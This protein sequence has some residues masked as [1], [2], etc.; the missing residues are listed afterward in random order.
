MPNRKSTK[1][2][3]ATS[4]RKPL[5]TF[6]KSQ[7]QSVV[8]AR[9][10]STR[11]ASRD[12][13]VHDPSTTTPA[14][15]GQAVGD[16]GIHLS[17]TTEAYM[18][19]IANPSDAPAAGMAVGGIPSEKMKVWSRGS[20]ATGT[21]GFG[22]I[23][24]RPATGAA[25][26]AG[27][28]AVMGVTSLSSYTGSTMSNVVG[29][30]TQAVIS[31]STYVPSQFSATGVKY[32]LVAAEVRVRYVGTEL[33]RGGNAVV[34]CDPNHN[35]VAAYGQAQLL[36]NPSAGR[37]DIE[38]AEWISCK[39]NG[40]VDPTEENYSFGFTEADNKANNWCMAIA[41]QSAAVAQPF[42]YE[43]YAH[44]EIIGANSTNLSSTISD[45]VG[46]GAVNTAA[47]TAQIEHP[48]SHEEPDYMHKLASGALHV[49]ANGASRVGDI[50]GQE[51]TAK[52]VVHAV[53][54]YAP[55]ISGFIGKYGKYAEMAAMLL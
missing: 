21:T 19:A 12:G 2:R 43:V 8:R 38:M 27:V 45:P 46:H 44:F 31:N 7:P 55:K 15:I 50:L 5:T 1:S 53:E 18:H 10:A 28:T 39:Y 32:R 9:S 48:G 33:N 11:I 52:A 3:R 26:G 25:T 41:I 40:V 4:V 37:S 20:F 16:V 14:R 34:Y 30:N 47:Q 42:D 35:S 17:P 51:G 6:P 54:K 23:L 22:Y 13:R 49:I 24:V 29:A 36:T